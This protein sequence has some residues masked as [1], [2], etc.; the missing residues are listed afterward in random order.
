[1]LEGSE[2][3][4]LED[5]LLEDELLEALEQELDKEDDDSTFA[6]TASAEYRAPVATF[7]TLYCLGDDLLLRIMSM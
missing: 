3:N 6:G 4:R 2:E 7:T 5:E 1:M